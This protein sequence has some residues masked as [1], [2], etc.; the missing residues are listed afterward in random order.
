LAAHLD[1]VAVAVADRLVEEAATAAT[2]APP[3]T[4]R[5]RV[6]PGASSAISPTGSLTRGTVAG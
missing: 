4:S 1:D 2:A 3:P 6:K 5:L